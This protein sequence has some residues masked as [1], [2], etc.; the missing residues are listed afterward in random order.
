MASKSNEYIES[1][2]VQNLIVFLSKIKSG[3]E[4]IFVFIT[5]AFKKSRIRE[6]LN[7]SMCA[8]SSTNIKTD[9]N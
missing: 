7:L 4:G 3:L 8:D 5:K 2:V 9:R 1:Y 6:A